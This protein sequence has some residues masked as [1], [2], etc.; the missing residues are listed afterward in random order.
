MVS[1]TYISAIVQISCLLSMIGSALVVFTWAYPIQNRSKHARILLFWLSVADFMTSFFYFFQTF[2]FQDSNETFCKVFALLDIFFPVASFIWTSFVA[3]YIYFVITMR[4]FP[5]V[6]VWKRMLFNFHVICWFVSLLV[7]VLVA[8][9]SKEGSSSADDDAMNDDGGLSNTGGW[10]WITAS[11]RVEKF[12]W[13]LIG[14]KFV[15]WLCCWVIVPLLYV[16]VILEIYS[17][18]R[19]RLIST[20]FPTAKRDVG[21]S[22][23]F[24]VS[25]FVAG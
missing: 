4:T 20:P 1:E 13:E 18:D 14:G 8:A 15:E 22:Q 3:Y 23:S 9:F 21:L 2:G 7:V 6:L 5:G 11:D 19:Q 12:Y 17:I 25:G 10:C 24:R 16:R